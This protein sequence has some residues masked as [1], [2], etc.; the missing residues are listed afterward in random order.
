MKKNGVIGLI[1]GV[2]AGVAAAVA[3]SL[4][5]VKVVKEIKEDLNESCFVSPEG[6]NFVSLKYGASNFAKGLVYIKVKAYTEAEKEAD[7]CNFSFLAGKNAKSIRVEWKDNEHF[8][9]SAGKGKLQQ[10]CDV[11][12]EGDNISIMYFWQKDTPE[13]AIEVVEVE[14]EA[15]A[16]E[17]TD[18]ENA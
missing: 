13:E 16:E 14:G 17:A 11:S 7:A 5:T 10:C 1:A 15:A 9:L 18:T 6:N 4:A 8:E 12:F 3:G 2:T